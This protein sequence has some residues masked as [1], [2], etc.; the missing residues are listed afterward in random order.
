MG[1][2][3]I[4]RRGGGGKLTAPPTITIVEE[5]R[6]GFTFNITNNDDNTALVVYE[7][8][9]YKENFELAPSETTQNIFLELP[10]GQYILKAYAAVVGEVVTEKSEVVQVA[11]IIPNGAFVAIA[12]ATE[13]ISEDETLSLKTFNKHINKLN[14][15]AILPI[16]NSAAVDLSSDGTY[17]ATASAISQPLLMLYKRSG[18]IFTK[19]S[20]PQQ[21]PSNVLGTSFSSDTNYL[22]IAFQVNP[23]VYIYKRSGDSFSVLS[24]SQGFN[25]QGFNAQFSPDTIYLSIGSQGTPFLNLYKRSGDTF[26]KLADPSILPSGS[27]WGLSFTSDGIYLGVGSFNSP[28]IQI[29]KRN[30][31]TFTKLANPATLPTG[32]GYRT[33]FSPDGTYLAIGHNNAPFITIYKRSGDTFTKIADPDVLPPNAGQGVAFSPDG[34]YLVVGYS[35][36]PNTTIYKRDGDTFTKVANPVTVPTGRNN[37]TK[38]SL[39]GNYLAIGHN[40]LPCITIYKQDPNE[41]LSEIKQFATPNPN[42]F[43]NYNLTQNL[44]ITDLG[45][46]LETKD[47]NEEVEFVS[48]WR[49][50]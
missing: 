31:D 21:P 10:E 50:P 22:A 16:N 34:N 3:L 13:P 6:F 49:R 28:F 9:Q 33:S 23:F 25:S 12:T 11:L 46:S 24:F 19:L 26:T 42:V 43:I 35:L 15:P 29:Y 45:Y 41:D 32:T 4:V 40:E 17:L 27:V 8:E 5:T 38:F 44:A 14:D 48:V 7:I 39:D 30:G 36:F 2:S 37:D 20:N 47:T 18:D 1:E